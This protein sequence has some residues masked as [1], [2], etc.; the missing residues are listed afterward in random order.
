MEGKETVMVIVIALI[1]LSI[2]LAIFVGIK[3]TSL[4]ASDEALCQASIIKAWKLNS[5]ILTNPLGKVKPHI[6]PPRLAGCKT[7]YARI[8]KKGITEDG[9]IVYDF[10]KYKQKD[11]DKRENY[12]MNFLANK[13]ASCWTMFRGNYDFTKIYKYVYG[14]RGFICYVCTQV[15]VQELPCG[16]ISYKKFEHYLNNTLI[17]VEHGN[18]LTSYYDYLYGAYGNELKAGSLNLQNQQPNNLPSTSPNIYSYDLIQYDEQLDTIR[19]GLPVEGIAY[20]DQNITEKHTYY[21][22]FE[23]IGSPI[24]TK[25]LPVILLV[26]INKAFINCNKM[27]S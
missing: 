6:S 9:K 8:D 15:D 10:S 21:I 11:C 3:N 1:S 26:D 22:L 12:T 19:S 25:P 23:V 7:K 20:P 5:F 14:S 16:N 13:M 27:F 4:E 18:D 2:L 17:K 24:S